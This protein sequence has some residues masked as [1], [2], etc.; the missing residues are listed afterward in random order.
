M[1][2]L[3]DHFVQVMMVVGLERLGDAAETLPKLIRF[4]RK[5]MN[6]LLVKFSTIETEKLINN[7][8]VQLEY[9]SWKEIIPWETEGAAK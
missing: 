2:K 8:Y 5:W 6:E 3:L 9:S 7:L 1:W 4:G